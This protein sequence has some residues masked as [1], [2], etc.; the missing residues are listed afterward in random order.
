MVNFVIIDDNIMHRKRV[1]NIICTYMM[2]NNVD[3][4]IYE[5]NDIDD[6]INDY[7]D[8]NIKNS[9]YILDLELPS[10]DGID[11]ATRV[12]NKNNDWVSPIIILTAHG[13]AYYKSYKE[14][15]QLLDFVCKSEDLIQF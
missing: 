2:D 15:L 14:R 11:V 12:R 9:I 6:K 4:K 10:H 3:F 5:F 7:I 13:G 1:Y 8:K